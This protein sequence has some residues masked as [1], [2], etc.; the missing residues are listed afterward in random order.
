M[1]NF[2]NIDDF[3][4]HKLSQ[5]QIEQKAWHWEAA[6]KLIDNQERKKRLGWWVLTVALP[7]MLA[8]PLLTGNSY[9]S[10]QTARYTQN[11]AKLSGLAQGKIL[12]KALT[13]KYKNSKTQNTNIVEGETKDQYL[14]LNGVKTPSFAEAFVQKTTLNNQN[15]AATNASDLVR[16]ERNG[17]LTAMKKF[18]PKA[19]EN[20]TETANIATATLAQN[21]PILPKINTRNSAISHQL[22]AE[23]GSIYW[24]K[25]LAINEI[26][27]TNR[28]HI[29]PHIALKYN[30]KINKIILSTGVGYTTQSLHEP[31]QTANQTN[32]GFGFMRNSYQIK[33]TKQH[34]LTIPILIG[35]EILPK[36]QIMAGM[37]VQK[38]LVSKYEVAQNQ[39]N[40][41]AGLGN[42]TQTNEYLSTSS[43]SIGANKTQMAGIARYQVQATQRLAAYIEYQKSFGRPTQAIGGGVQFFINK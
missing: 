2:E 11:T 5:S 15:N 33:N 40:S 17:L 25:T 9:A 43:P 37:S 22:L 36:H 30:L 41:L 29:A 6:E 34:Q 24:R 12:Y 32:Y 14:G 39:L 27:T 10:K 42:A 18:A 31:T 28:Q 35:Y 21:T 16:L 13:Q 8:L 19:I 7:L 23:V 3:L 26:D 38:T 4:R 20:T 1:N